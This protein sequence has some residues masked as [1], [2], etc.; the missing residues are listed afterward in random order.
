MKLK[1]TWA[2]LQTRKKLIDAFKSG[3]IHL[4][5][6]IDKDNKR[7]IFPKIH[8]VDLEKESTTI[9]FTLPNGLNPDLLKKNF[10]AFQ[11]HFGKNI[12]LDGEIKK[13]SLTVYHTSM[14]SELRYNF[15]QIKPVIAPFSLGIICGKDRNGQYVAFDLLQQPHILIAGE[16]GSGKSTQLRSILTTLIKTKKPN[17]LELYLGDC[18]KSEFH[19][20]RKVEHVQCVHSSARDIQRMLLHIKKEL[21]ERSDLTEMFE[22]SHVDDLPAEHRKPYL[23][24]CIDE[25]VMLRKDELIMD[26]LTEIVAIGRTLGVYAILSMQRPNAKVLDTTIRANLT[27]SMGFK[28]RD[29]MESKIVNTPDAHKIETSGR[30]VMNSDKLYEI[31]APYLTMEKAKKFLNPFM[32]AKGSAKDVTDKP[33]E[34]TEKDVFNDVN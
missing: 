20:F 24:V 5:Y 14:P 2:K 3:E 7:L 10:F 29:A 16:T 28:L 13:Y 15:E 11:Q 1:E 23:V 17:E 30:F 25:F 6:K 8:S 4:T 9:T 34:L 21:D 31:Q 26:I 32:V 27:V 12:E 33:K 19:L 22:V 18:K